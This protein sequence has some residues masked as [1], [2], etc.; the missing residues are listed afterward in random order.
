M[1]KWIKKYRIF[2]T[3][4][5]LIIIFGIPFLIHVLFKIHPKNDFWVA[6]WTAGDLLGY[7]GA[8]LAFIGTVVLGMLALYQNH[9]IKIESDKRAELLEQRERECNM[10]KFSAS[11]WQCNGFTSNLKFSIKNISENSASDIVVQNIKIVK[12]D[13]TVFWNAEHAYKKDALIS[14]EEM[15]IELSNSSIREDGYTFLMEMTCRDKFNEL[16]RYIIKGNH[17]KVDTFPKFK[18]TEIQ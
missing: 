18:I 3:L 8:I 15:K 6:E 16:H 12:P 1:F 10:P 13:N 11:C 2:V 5:S 14:T 17:E 4:L 9:I 7:Y